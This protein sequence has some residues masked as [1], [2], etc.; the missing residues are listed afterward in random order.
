MIYIERKS[1]SCHKNT[2]SMIFGGLVLVVH[3][4]SEKCSDRW[5]KIVLTFFDSFIW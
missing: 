4:G 5:K 3:L 1:D 2:I